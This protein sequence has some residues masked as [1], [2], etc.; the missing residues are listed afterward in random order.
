M[1]KSVLYYE[2]L[3][4]FIGYVLS[5]TDNVY[6]ETYGRF[7][8]TNSF[9]IPTVGLGVVNVALK[10]DN[11]TIASATTDFNNQTV[12]EGESLDERVSRHELYAPDKWEDSSDD[13]YAKT[14]PETPISTIYGDEIKTKTDDSFLLINTKLD[15]IRNPRPVDISLGI[16]CELPSDTHDEI[17]DMSVKYILHAIENSQK[18]QLT[19]AE[20]L[21]R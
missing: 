14:S 17:V 9:L 6:W 10:S 4:Q 1:R 20:Y 5:N 16:G 2:E 19:T 15:Y 18:Y 8:S 11:K 7:S 12:L 13:P 21:N 3:Y